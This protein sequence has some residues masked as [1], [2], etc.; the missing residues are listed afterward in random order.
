MAEA[1]SG[2]WV[3]EYGTAHIDDINPALCNLSDIALIYAAVYAYLQVRAGVMEFG[4]LLQDFRYELA[5]V[6]ARV[7]R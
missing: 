2:L 1:L 6:K 5:A 7:D 3:P 4:Y